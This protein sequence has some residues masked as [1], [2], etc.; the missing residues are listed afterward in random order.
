MISDF[1]IIFVST[2][3]GSPKTVTEFV[4]TFLL[5]GIK[6][7]EIH[8]IRTRGAGSVPPFVMEKLKGIRWVFHDI[9]VE[10]IDTPANAR[11]ALHVI[12][13]TIF[14]LKNGSDSVLYMD[15]TGGRKPM[16]AYLTLAA[17]IFCDETDRLFHVE[18]LDP[19][20]RDPRS[21]KW[22]PERESDVRLTE[23]PYVRLYFLRELAANWGYQLAPENPD[24]ILGEVTSLLDELALL[25]FSL[26]AIAHEIGNEIGYLRLKLED[27]LGSTEK[28]AFDN[29]H[30]LLEYVM[31]FG[32]SEKLRLERLS[33]KALISEAF[34]EFVARKG[35]VLGFQLSGEDGEIEGARVLLKRVFRNFF[36]NSLKA[37]ATAVKVKLEPHE[38]VIRVYVSDNGPGIPREL[39][40]RI[41]SIK[42]EGKSGYG[43]GLLLVKKILEKHGTSVSF[44]GGDVGATFCIDFKKGGGIEEDAVHNRG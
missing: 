5:K 4:G 8:V 32:R 11:K 36:D 21:D 3:G 6:P 28:I 26:Q 20:L 19:L 22:F 40:D 38:D 14:D 29:I 24:R 44:S 18:P 34:D 33:L 37:G 42:R 2:L 31:I 1:S 13:R 9:G 23:I 27:A 15:L 16:S 17:Q 25:G 39:R 30:S 12:F 7:S 10:D 35:A 41:F 43:V